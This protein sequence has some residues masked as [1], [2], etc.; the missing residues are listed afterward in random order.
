MTNTPLAHSLER[1]LLHPNT[2]GCFVASLGGVWL[3]GRAV[4]RSGR[5]SYVVIILTAIIGL[6]ALL[7]GVFGEDVLEPRTGT[8]A[9][10]APAT[11]CIRACTWHRQKGRNSMKGGP[12]CWCSHLSPTSWLLR[13]PQLGR[14]SRPLRRPLRR[15]PCAVADAGK[16]VNQCVHRSTARFGMLCSS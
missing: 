13:D 10:A 12:F 7:T 15:L 16:C 5:A 14:L 8:D 3:V 1:R 4:R 2:A 9:A 6:G 11:A